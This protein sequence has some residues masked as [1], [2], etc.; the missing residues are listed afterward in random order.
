MYKSLLL[1]VITTH[2]LADN[3]ITINKQQLDITQQQLQK[4]G[5]LAIDKITQTKQALSEIK[6][7]QLNLS[8]VESEITLANPMFQ[9]TTPLTNNLPSGDKYYMYSKSVVSDTKQALTQYKTP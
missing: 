4:S 6:L 2:V 3:S 1:I 8:K 5:K 7:D 9:H